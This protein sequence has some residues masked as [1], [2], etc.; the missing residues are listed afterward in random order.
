MTTPEP[1]SSSPF[2][3]T[4]RNTVVCARKGFLH[5]EIA[6]LMMVRQHEEKSGRSM[7][8]HPFA[9]QPLA[10]SFFDFPDMPTPRD[11]ECVMFHTY[12][13][14]DLPT[15]GVTVTVM[16]STDVMTQASD[17]CF[18][19]FEQDT[20]DAYFA[21]LYIK[22]LSYED[23]ARVISDCVATNALREED[24]AKG[25]IFSEK[26]KLLARGAVENS[27]AY[28][29]DI[30]TGST[31]VT[32]KVAFADVGCMGGIN[33]T[34]AALHTAHPQAAITAV[35]YCRRDASGEVGASL[36]DKWSLRCFSEDYVTAVD[37][38]M[39]YILH[40]GRA[41][42]S[43]RGGMPGDASTD[44]VYQAGG[45]SRFPFSFFSV[46]RA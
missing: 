7:V 38:F 9:N 44:M 16:S 4:H 5:E 45:T 22:T 2:I 24:I 32:T 10:S 21:C 12:D 30:I 46:R 42:G 41:W 14:T 27:I 33:T 40:C 23:R 31:Y 17:G 19:E 18:R 20:S 34:H 25:R 15:S 29:M 13:T 43:V 39:R 11:C 6:A 28:C 37:C 35:H 3:A 26:E 8:I 1:S 36:V